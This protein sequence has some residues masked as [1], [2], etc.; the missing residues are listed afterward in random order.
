MKKKLEHARSMQRHSILQQNETDSDDDDNVMND[1][2]SLMKGHRGAGGRGRKRH[3]A[4]RTERSLSVLQKE[5]ILGSAAAYEASLAKKAKARERKAMKRER[6]KQYA[7]LNPVPND[8]KKTFTGNID[9]DFK[10]WISL[11]RKQMKLYSPF[12][13][14]DLI[15]ASPLGLRRVMGGRRRRRQRDRFLERSIS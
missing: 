12:F 13:E 15:V 1:D 14:S 4:D 9:D 3:K 5:S 11:S 6:D 7:L 10:L 8:F 2:V